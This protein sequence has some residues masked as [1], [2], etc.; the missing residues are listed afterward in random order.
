M[1]SVITLVVVALLASFAHADDNLGYK[2]YRGELKFKK[3]YMVFGKADG[4]PVPYEGKNGVG[5]RY[6]A[7]LTLQCNKPNEIIMSPSMS[8]PNFFD[9]S[10]PGNMASILG[11]SY[12]SNHEGIPNRVTVDTTLSSL[13][14]PYTLR[15]SALC[16][17][18][19]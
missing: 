7:V 6:G 9:N 16:C 8:T 18:Y 5:G 3:C 1:R 12:A 17:R 13:E 10:A 19:R 4:G 15:M 2:P 11:I 14:R